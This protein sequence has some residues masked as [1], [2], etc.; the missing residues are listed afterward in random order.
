MTTNTLRIAVVGLG[1]MGMGMA[2][3]LV[4]K[5]HA[6]IGVDMN[7]DACAALRAA[8][9]EIAASPKDAAARADALVLVVVNAAQ[10]EEVLFGPDGA[11]GALPK[12]RVV[13]QCATVPPGFIKAL[14][15]RLASAGHPLLDAPM[16][17]GRARADTGEL[18]IMSSG[19]V[20]AYDQ[21]QPILDAV[22]AK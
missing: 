5:G 9:G 12:G 19:A 13:M 10:V 2:K 11:I 3:N 22:A 14:G 21:A 7:Q 20:A 15:E 8:G 17:G 6:V 4:A 16:S 18:T 1:S